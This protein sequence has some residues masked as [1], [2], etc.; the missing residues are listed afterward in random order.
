MPR[1][2]WASASLRHLLDASRARDRFWSEGGTAC[3]IPLDPPPSVRL[4]ADAA[5]HLAAGR[6][7][8]ARACLDE[9]GHDSGDIR[10]ADDVLGPVLEVYTAAG[11]FWV[12]WEHVQ[13]LEVDPPRR[14]R[15]LLWA[16]AKLAT[17]DGQLGE[18]H[19]PATYPGTAAGPDGPAKVGRA[20]EWDEPVA[21]I[22]RGRGAKLFLVGD[23]ART[24]FELGTYQHGP[25][26][27]GRRGPRLIMAAS[28]PMIEVNDFLAPISDRALRPEPP[29]RARIRRDPRGPPRRR[30]HAPGDWARKVKSAD[31][32][33]VVDARPRHPQAS[34][35]KDLQIAAWVAEAL[36]RRAGAAGLRDGLRLL[37]QI[38]ERFWETYHPQI[39]D[40][41]VESRYGPFLFLN[42]TLPR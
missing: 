22:V 38:Q 18:V 25:G 4:H 14:L 40:D 13:F 2:R 31:F 19:L 15:D 16:P 24:L 35:S 28:P 36:T 20:T 7:D 32:E 23:D 37:H 41:E 10:D 11:Y 27:D 39:E 5:G 33:R 1:R 3:G 30:R 17:L 21:G 6:L 12:P 26:D 8:A 34:K 42:K 29:V 9:A